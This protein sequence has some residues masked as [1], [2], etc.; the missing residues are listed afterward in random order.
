[1]DGS[2]SMASSKEELASVTTQLVEDLEKLST[3]MKLGFGMFVDKPVLPYTDMFVW[4][5]LFI[6]IYLLIYFIHL[7]F[8]T[9][10][11]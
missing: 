6:F 10:F 1:M 7:L 2:K 8:L 11:Y 9:Y 4:R 5:Y 3:N